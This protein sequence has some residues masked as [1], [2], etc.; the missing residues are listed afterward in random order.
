MPSKSCRVT[1]S[2]M[3]GVEHTAHVS[4]ET[5]YEA[6]ALGLVAIHRHS[7]SEEL[8]EGEVKVM[9]LDTPVEHSVNLRKFNAWLKRPGGAPKD[10]VNRIR[11]QE[12]LGRKA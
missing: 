4:A 8:T 5:L 9:V 11:V 10:M 2:D 12:I 7:W 6:V 3:E 1:I